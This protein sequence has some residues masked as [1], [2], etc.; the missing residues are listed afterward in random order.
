MLQKYKEFIV[1]LNCLGVP[2]PMVRD[3]KT[4]VGSVSLTLVF[5]SFNVWLF[6]VI[7]K[8]AGKAGGIDTSACLQM[9]IACAGLYYGRKLSTK[10]KDIELQ[11][12]EE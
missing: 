4:K 6:S 1:K 11:S 10:G 9:F 2:V 7:G 5:L 3:P 12:K 8:I